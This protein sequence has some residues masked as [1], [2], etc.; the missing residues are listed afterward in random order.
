VEVAPGRARY[1]KRAFFLRLPQGSTLTDTQ[2]NLGLAIR[3]RPGER[4]ENKHTAVRFAKGLYLLYGPSVDQVFR[5][6]DG[7]GAATDRAPVLAERLEQEFLRLL[8]L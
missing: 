4:I 1:M 6:K 3:L 7:S 5:S 8:E 2:F